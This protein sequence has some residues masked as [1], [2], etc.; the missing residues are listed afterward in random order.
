MTPEFVVVIKQTIALF[1]SPLSSKAIVNLSHE[2]ME[3]ERSIP[4]LSDHATFSPASRYSWQP[5]KHSN[6]E[7]RRNAQRQNQPHSYFHSRDDLV[8]AWP[9][10]RPTSTRGG[11]LAGSAFTSH[12]ER[13]HHHIHEVFLL[14]AFP[15]PP[16]QG[17]PV[18]FKPGPAPSLVSRLLSAAHGEVPTRQSES[19]SLSLALPGELHAVSSRPKNILVFPPHYHYLCTTVTS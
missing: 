13:A 10:S 7:L 16:G 15:F 2:K 6:T 8:L 1:S 9:A 4:S 18:V 17:C 3:R 11:V 19:S 14:L 12:W 5:L